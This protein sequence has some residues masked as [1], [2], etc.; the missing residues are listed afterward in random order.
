MGNLE[1]GSLRTE[2]LKFNLEAPKTPFHKE[3]SLRWSY[4][5]LNVPLNL[6]GY[7]RDGA[8]N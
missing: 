6:Q 2:K 4:V 8:S 5:F 1:G 3:L 7:L